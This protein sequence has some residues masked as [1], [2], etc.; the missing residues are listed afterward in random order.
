MFPPPNAVRFKQKNLCVKKNGRVLSFVRNSRSTVSNMFSRSDRRAE[1][2]TN[3]CLVGNLHNLLVPGSGRECDST[4]V[5]RSAA[6][7]WCWASH[8][9]LTV[10][11]Y[12]SDNGNGSTDRPPG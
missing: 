3:E 6:V 12:E 4:V 10:T 9:R 2:E 8:P 11:P 1:H 7:Y 5:V